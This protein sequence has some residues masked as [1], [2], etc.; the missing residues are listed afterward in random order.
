[1][2]GLSAKKVTDIHGRVGREHYR[3]VFAAEDPVAVARYFDLLVTTTVK[4]M[5]VGTPNRP[6]VLGPVLGYIGTVEAQGRGSLHAHA[7]IWASGV[8]SQ[9]EIA[10]VLDKATNE[11]NAFLCPKRHH[12]WVNPYNGWIISALRLS[13]NIWPL[14]VTSR[15]PANIIYSVTNYIAK[16]P[17]PTYNT[18][19]LL[20]HLHAIM[21]RAEE[22]LADDSTGPSGL[23]LHNKET[24]NFTNRPTADKVS[25]IDHYIHRDD[26][27]LMVETQDGNG[28]VVKSKRDLSL[29]ELVQQFR[30][31]AIP[32]DEQGRDR[33]RDGVRPGAVSPTK[34]GR[35]KEDRYYFRDTHPQ[36]K[37]LRIAKRPKRDVPVPLFN[38]K[39]SQPAD[40]GAA[41]SRAL[42]ALILFELFHDTA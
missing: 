10:T 25:I 5:I 31:E 14:M 28:N 1:M 16:T 6:G 21:E 4:D 19:A 41:E 3:R 32:K 17:P 27:L 33:P 38:K 34:R 12:H 39:L 30:F 7:S 9:T 26:D 8:S 13:M 36:T 37:T 40:I 35:H 2:S 20:E 42:I 11:Y 15:N 24:V 22:E 29:Y 18:Y 23:A